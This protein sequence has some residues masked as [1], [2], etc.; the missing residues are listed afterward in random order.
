M[1]LNFRSES[2]LV[3]VNELLTTLFGEVLTPNDILIIVGPFIRSRSQYSL[4]RGF[5]CL[6]F[7]GT[8]GFREGPVK[9]NPALP[10][11]IIVRSSYLVFR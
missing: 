2:I 1:L 6:I 9:P 5:P 8:I 7:A 11:Y 10:M 3:R 4:A